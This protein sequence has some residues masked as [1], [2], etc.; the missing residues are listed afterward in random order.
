LGGTALAGIAALAL[1]ANAGQ[2]GSRD[3]MSV[4]LGGELR[5]NVALI[6]QDVSATVGRGYQFR[7]DESEIK[8][9]AKSTADNGIEYGV[10]IELNAGAGDGSAADEAWAFIDSDN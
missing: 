5:F 3:S 2:V 9:N 8:I 6:D 1:P 10:G 7:V 4:S